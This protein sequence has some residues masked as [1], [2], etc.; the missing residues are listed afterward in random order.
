[1]GN[2]Q[3]KSKCGR[4]SRF[5]CMRGETDSASKM[6]NIPA[7]CGRLERSGYRNDKN[8]IYI[9][10]YLY[11]G[12][13]YEHCYN[14]CSNFCS[15]LKHISLQLFPHYEPEWFSVQASL[16]LVIHLNN[17]KIERYVNVCMLISLFF[18]LLVR[19]RPFYG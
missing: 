7:R 15:I 14:I 9:F 1:M 2:K 19:N 13:S 4:F 18:G 12:K 10:I 3:K 16:H 5:R 17:L 11:C 8:N 6:R